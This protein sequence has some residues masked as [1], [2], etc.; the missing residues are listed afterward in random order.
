M[1]LT[2]WEHCPGRPMRTCSYAPFVDSSSLPEPSWRRVLLAWSID[3]FL[4]VVVY[5]GLVGT[6][7]SNVEVSDAQSVFL[8][9]GLAFAV[10]LLYGAVCRRGR[11][12]GC[13][14][15]G[16]AF[17][18]KGTQQR[19]TWGGTVRTVLLRWWMPVLGILGVLALFS[20]ESGGGEFWESSHESRRVR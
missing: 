15:A 8:L 20:L 6:I 4:L 5:I 16:T 19:A 17:V 7:A 18:R 12:L 14:V 11:T 1:C 10:P 9:L 2:T 13:L 3:Q